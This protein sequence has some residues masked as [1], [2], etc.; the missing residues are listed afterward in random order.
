M[1]STGRNKV[2]SESENTGWRARQLI[3]M[4][5]PKLFLRACV[6]QEDVSSLE[7]KQI[8]ALLRKYK[9]DVYNRPV[10][11]LRFNYHANWP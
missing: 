9:P 3:A 6:L 8:L 11:L 2:R 1:K 10:D 5:N 7:R 4:K